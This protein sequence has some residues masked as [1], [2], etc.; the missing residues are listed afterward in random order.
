MSESTIF[1]VTSTAKIVPVVLPPSGDIST[2]GRI[3]NIP[4][5]GA[6]HSGWL[7]Y[8]D[9]FGWVLKREKELAGFRL[10]EDMYRAE[11]NAEGWE[12]YRRYLSDWRAGRTRSS[13]PSHLLPKQVQ[14][15]Q[16]GE[17]A[18]EHRDPWFLPAPAPTTGA[19]SEPKGKAKESREVA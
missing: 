8:A 16:R 3:R 10:L 1:N 17:V 5:R 12:S 11:N 19:L 15:W 4:I 18:P 6:D 9:G 14:A 2:S 13:F 7:T